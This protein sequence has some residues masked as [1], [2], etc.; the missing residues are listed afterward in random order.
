MPLARGS[1]VENTVSK[2]AAFGVSLSGH[3]QALFQ[4]NTVCECSSG[5][6][7]AGRGHGEEVDAGADEHHLVRP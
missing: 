2:A 5:V 4:S 6:V 1:F 3:S 7:A